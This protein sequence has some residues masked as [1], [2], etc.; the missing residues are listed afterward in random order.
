METRWSHCG[1][2]VCFSGKMLKSEKQK[3][4]KGKK[5]D[6]SKKEEMVKKKREKTTVMRVSS[7]F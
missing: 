4:E 5:I 2:E 7:D 6:E 3:R 1:H